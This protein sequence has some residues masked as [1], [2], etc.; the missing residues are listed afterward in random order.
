MGVCGRKK[1]SLSG[2]IHQIGPLSSP[3]DMIFRQTERDC[4]NKNHEYMAYSLCPS[5]LTSQEIT[6]SPE[7]GSMPCV[8]S[9][10]FCF[11]I[12]EVE[13]RSAYTVLWDCCFVCQKTKVWR[14]FYK[15]HPF[16]AA[17]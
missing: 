15:R 7:R 14:V 10:L 1:T 8:S 13:E 6:D 5:V 3:L 11:R 2:L 17:V 4:V 12:I 9:Q 16:N